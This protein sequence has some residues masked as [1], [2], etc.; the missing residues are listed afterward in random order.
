MVTETKLYYVILLF[1]MFAI[2]YMFNYL[3]NFLY[4]PVV[5]Y[6]LYVAMAAVTYLRYDHGSSDL[7]ILFPW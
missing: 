1:A 4:I 2:I 6:S 3:G 5:T 7:T